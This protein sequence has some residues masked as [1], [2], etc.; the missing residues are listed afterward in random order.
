MIIR[1]VIGALFI[2]V[3]ALSF[4]QGASADPAETQKRLKYDR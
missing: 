2:G 4:P 1:I 3:L